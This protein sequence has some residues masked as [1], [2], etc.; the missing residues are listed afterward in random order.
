MSKKITLFFLLTAAG[1]MFLS[2]CSTKTDVKPNPTPQTSPS[3]DLKDF[4]NTGSG[5][6]HLSVRGNHSEYFDSA[7]A[8]LDLIE[9][10]TV[11]KPGVDSKYVTIW[12]G[13]ENFDDLLNMSVGIMGDLGLLQIPAGTYNQARCHVFNGWA[14]KNKVKYPVIFPG[15]RMD[16][17]FQPPITVGWHVSPDLVLVI[18]VTNQFVP[19]GNPKNPTGYIF[20]PQVTA[21]NN[22]TT[23]SIVGTIFDGSTGLPILGATVWVMVGTQLVKTTT[24]TAPNDYGFQPGDFILPDLP[25]GTYTVYASQSGYVSNSTSVY[26]LIANYNPTT[27]TLTPK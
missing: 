17:D 25:G 16:L 10:K 20:R 7:G 19:I 4:C 13:F 12:N 26:C 1:L 5:T 24:L 9:L 27:I 15:D 6:L 18:D 14:C 22:T 2:S 8:S 3:K 23:G 11:G 21:I